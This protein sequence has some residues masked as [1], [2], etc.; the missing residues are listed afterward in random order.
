VKKLTNAFQGKR[1]VAIPTYS[2][3]PLF[4]F[5]LQEKTSA[6]NYDAAYLLTRE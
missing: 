4:L 2:K 1:T 6:F 3:A 5:A